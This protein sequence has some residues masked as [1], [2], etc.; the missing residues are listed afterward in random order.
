MSA[1]TIVQT[2]KLPD[3]GVSIFAVMSK[4]AHE[5]GA[6]NLSQGF[7][8]FDCDARLVDLVA[9]AMRDGHNQ[10]APMQGLPALR[11]AIAAKIARLYGGRY[12]P[13]TDITVT[14]GGTEAVFSTISA[15]IRPGDEVIVFEPSYD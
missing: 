2:S 11:D 3:V 8:D 4:L 13:A 5:H 6:I 10:Y 7:P 12:D 15:F 14:S 1:H 9:N